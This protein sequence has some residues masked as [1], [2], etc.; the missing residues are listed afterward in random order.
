M[1]VKT[2]GDISINDVYNEF[3]AQ[4]PPSVERFIGRDPLRIPSYYGQGNRPL[5]KFSNY[6]GASKR[7][8]LLNP[9]ANNDSYGRY[10]YARSNGYFYYLSESSQSGSSF[11]GITRLS[12]L[13]TGSRQLACIVTNNTE[14]NGST[15]VTIGFSGGS[16]SSNGGFTTVEFYPGSFNSV[17]IPSLNWT[18]SSNRLSR[19]TASFYTL[20]GTSP[21]VYAYRWNS[22][23][24]GG[25][26][27]TISNMIKNAAQ[28]GGS[29][30]VFV[31]FT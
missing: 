11:G 13:A 19:S 3:G 14:A 17:G 29:S 8:T 10:G 25:N 5:T 23:T 16:S 26:V 12:S 22:S 24:N 7:T 15:S 31:E 2:S 27:T 28:N 9:S 30:R 18:Q 6:Y 21:T 4:P 1:A 20:P